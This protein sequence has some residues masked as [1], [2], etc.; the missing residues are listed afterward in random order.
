[1]TS[2]GERRGASGVLV[3]KAEGKRPFVR[4]KCKWWTVLKLIV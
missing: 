3:R 2:E 1:M 4:R